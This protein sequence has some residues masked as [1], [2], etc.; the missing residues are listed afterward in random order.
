VATVPIAS[1]TKIKNNIY[2]YIY[3]SKQRKIKRI[4]ESVEERRNK[5]DGVER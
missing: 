4:N 1:Q 3:I 2:I 5:K